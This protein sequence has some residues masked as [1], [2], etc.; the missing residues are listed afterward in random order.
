M[1][2]VILRT[3]KHQSKEYDAIIDNKTVSFGASDY[4]IHKDEERKNN[5]DAR[6]KPSENWNDLTTAGALFQ[7]HILRFSTHYY[8]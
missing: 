4:T 6:H 8:L 3:S 7:C 5:Y 2:E 1:R